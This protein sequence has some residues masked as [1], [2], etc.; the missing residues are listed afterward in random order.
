M[1][2][3]EQT[4]AIEVFAAAARTASV[5]S[6]SIDRWSYGRAT[7]QNWV[8]S[9]GAASGT[10]PTLNIKVQ[11]SEDNSTW[12]DVAGAAFTQTT[13]A[14]FKQLP[15]RNFRRYTRAVVTIAGTTPSFTFSLT[16]T[17]GD[18]VEGNI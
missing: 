18:P 11:D 9:V 4:E 5:N 15:V 14:A 17:V 1:A 7:S 6:S 13:A 8:L 12:V 16:C 10:T 2:F 3:F